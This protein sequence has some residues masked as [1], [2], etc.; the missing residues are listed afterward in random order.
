MEAKLIAL[1]DAD[2]TG[3]EAFRI[4]TSEFLRRLQKRRPGVYFR[5]ALFLRSNF[6]KWCNFAANCVQS[7]IPSQ[8]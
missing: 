1:H 5:H 3:A 7:H 8:K 6:P 4:L 2:A